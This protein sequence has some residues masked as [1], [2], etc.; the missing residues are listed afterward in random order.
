VHLFSW[1][2]APAIGDDALIFAAPGFNGGENGWFIIEG[3]EVDSLIEEV[4]ELDRLRTEI[5]Q[6]RLSCCEA[7]IKESHTEKASELEKKVNEKFKDLTK[8]PSQAIQ[9]LLLVK[10]NKR[11]GKLSK[12]VYIRPYQTRNG[13]VKGHFRRNS[14]THVKKALQKWLKQN[15]EN[16]KKE[17][18][19]DAKLKAMIW[20]SDSIEKNWPWKFKTIENADK[21]G[22][23]TNAGY[24]SIAYEAQF[25]RFLAGA[26]TSSEFDLKQM[27]IKLTASANASYSLAEGTFSGKWS[28]PDKDGFDIFEYLL[29]SKNAKDTLIKKNYKCMFRFTLEARAK[30]FVGVN[31]T[32]AVALPCIDLSKKDKIE[33]GKNKTVSAGI[34]TSGFAGAS[35]DGKLIS[36]VEW[37]KDLSTS[38]KELA[39]FS[40]MGG[41]RAGVGGEVKFEVKYENGKFRIETGIMAVVGIGGKCGGAFEL[42]VNEGVAL[43]AHLFDS[44][45]FHYMKA[46]AN[47]AFDAYVN[48]TLERYLF[49]GAVTEKFLK[50][51][52]LWIKEVSDKEYKETKQTIRKTIQDSSKFKISPPETLG[53]LLQTIVKV[54]E[55]DDFEAILKVLR[56]AEGRD[57]EGHK[58]KWIIRSF[59]DPELSKKKEKTGDE[60]SKFALEEGIRKLM[61]FGKTN[62]LEA[63]YKRYVSN[64]K[65]LLNEN[66]ITF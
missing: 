11:W 36:I 64:L 7:K 9:E 57:D 6:F 28:L 15:G 14:D 49:L 62:L 63:Y 13:I 30:C 32:A 52:K 40:A 55:E 44:V 18:E 21:S 10:K 3:D 56:S 60:E 50:G 41:G 38:F 17:F 46:V 31:I 4:N 8:N 27:T 65:E 34:D 2:R 59:H 35:V 47:E 12:R 58:L 33:S 48:T 25:L 39:E 37:S 26:N 61:E 20:E 24:F 29:L 1:L 45:N 22:I 51:F 43:I 53:Q 42:N 23:D 19:I 54:P 66:K 16:K 5:E